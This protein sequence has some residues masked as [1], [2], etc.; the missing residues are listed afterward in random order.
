M[1][2]HHSARGTLDAGV[3]L[4]L[5]HDQGKRQ[6]QVFFLK[7]MHLSL[8]LLRGQSRRGWGICLQP[9]LKVWGREQRW[10]LEQSR[11]GVRGGVD[12]VAAGAEPG[13]RVGPRWV[14]ELGSMRRRPWY[15]SLHTAHSWVVVIYMF[16][17]GSSILSTCCCNNWSQT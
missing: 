7:V 5:C 1:V 14:A 4:G 6:V 16:V 17:F 2:P 13:P 8:C 12:V 9:L 3:Y 11:S 10:C 15:S